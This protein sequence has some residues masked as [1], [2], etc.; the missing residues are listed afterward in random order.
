MKTFD[1]GKTIITRVESEIA[2][3]SQQRVKGYADIRGQ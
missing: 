3:G 2:Y 1:I